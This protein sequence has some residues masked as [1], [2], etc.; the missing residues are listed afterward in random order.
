MDVRA[1]ILNYTIF[2]PA[3]FHYIPKNKFL[4]IENNF[5]KLKK[6]FKSHILKKKDRNIFL[7]KLGKSIVSPAIHSLESSHYF[8]HLEKI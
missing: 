2:G 7:Y 3:K 6:K 4:K 5:Q 1:R 8:K